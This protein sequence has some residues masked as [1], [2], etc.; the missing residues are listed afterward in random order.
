M[1]IVILSLVESPLF[2][3]TSGEFDGDAGGLVVDI[4]AAGGVV[5]RVAVPAEEVAELIGVSVASTYRES[6]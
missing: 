2:P 1:P 6:L 3:T 5:G 4:V